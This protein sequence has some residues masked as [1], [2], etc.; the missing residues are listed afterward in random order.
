[1]ATDHLSRALLK[2]VV[3]TARVPDGTSYTLAY[4]LG[5]KGERELAF[6]SSSRFG[7]LTLL[8]LMLEQE[9]ALAPGS[10]CPEVLPLE[11]QSLEVQRQVAYRRSFGR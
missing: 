3:T 8:P 6:A 1:M 5:P 2:E 7:D 4:V 10:H 9:I 11:Q